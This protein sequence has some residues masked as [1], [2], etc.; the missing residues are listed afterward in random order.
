MLKLLPQDLVIRLDEQR[1]VLQFLVPKSPG[2]TGELRVFYEMSEDEL[3]EQ[4]E[5][6]HQIGVS[7]LSFLSATYSSTVFHLEQYRDAA[8]HVTGQWEAERTQE[9][10]GKSAKGNATAKY[11]LGMQKVAQGLRTKSA[12]TM[13]EAEMLFKEAATLGNT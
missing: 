7:L 4:G 8:K 2:D 5:F 12:I 3:D 10:Q 13:N 11:E 6:E 1:R 9:L